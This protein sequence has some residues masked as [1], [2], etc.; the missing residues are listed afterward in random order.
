MANAL[1]TKGK[2]NILDGA[3]D[4]DTDTI[5]AFLVD[6]A[7]YTLNISTDD[8]L[9]DI[10]TGARKGNNGNTGRTDAPQ[11]TSPSITDGVFDA[12]N[13]TF[14]SVSTGN[15]YEYIVIFKDDGVADSS[16]PLVACIDTAASGL[17]VTPNGGDITVQWDDGANK[18]FKL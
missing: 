10:P 15:T 3:I 8:Y 2:Q 18:I 16:S 4:F 1:Y 13:T 11:L 6:S 9:D 17:P 5:R 7:S 14:S 12:A